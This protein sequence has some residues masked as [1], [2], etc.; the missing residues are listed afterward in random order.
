MQLARFRSMGTRAALRQLPCVTESEA[1][2]RRWDG[3]GRQLDEV[4][5]AMADGDFLRALRLARVAAR[6]LQAAAGPEHPDHAALEA[7]ITGRRRKP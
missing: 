5:A 7:I 2:S 3:A 6:E 1:E 4:A